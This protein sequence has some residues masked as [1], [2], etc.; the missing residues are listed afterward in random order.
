MTK[1]FSLLLLGGHHGLPNHR[2][3]SN[4]T[5]KYGLGAGC[6][7]SKILYSDLPYPD[8]V[9]IGPVPEEIS[10]QHNS[11]SSSLTA[12]AEMHAVPQLLQQKISERV[13]VRL[14]Q[15]QTVDI[16]QQDSIPTINLTTAGLGWHDRNG[17]TGLTTELLCLDPFYHLRATDVTSAIQKVPHFTTEAADVCPVPSESSDCYT[18]DKVIRVLKDSFKCP[19]L[20]VFT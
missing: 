20:S 19:V 11:L 9:N 3:V 13:N 8:E 17:Y 1:I 15:L 18:T 14:K 10:S 5:C 2:C 12:G 6:F 16:L 4:P 7:S